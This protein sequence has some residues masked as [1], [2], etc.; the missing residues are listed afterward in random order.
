[1]FHNIITIICD[2]IFLLIS[3]NSGKNYLKPLIYRRQN[4]APLF[5]IKIYLLVIFLFNFFVVL[6]LF[7]SIFSFL[8][9]IFFYL[10]IGCF[11]GTGLVQRRRLLLKWNLLWP[12]YLSRSFFE[13]ITWHWVENIFLKI[14]SSTSTSSSLSLQMQSPTV[15]FNIDG[16]TDTLTHTI[17][18]IHTHT[19]YTYKHAFKW[20]FSC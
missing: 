7:Y 14:C 6:F 9:I 15:T 16:Q 12:T 3:L 20:H 5:S 8:N 13:N 4:L 10:L 11:K 1:M 19:T 17:I 18:N 2:F